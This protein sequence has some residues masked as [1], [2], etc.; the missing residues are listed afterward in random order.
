M[1]GLGQ[2]YPDLVISSPFPKRTNQNRAHRAAKRGHR[3]FASQIL[4]FFEVFRLEPVTTNQKISENWVLESLTQIHAVKLSDT[5]I[6]TQTTP[7][8]T[9]SLL[10]FTISYLPWI[11]C[12][13]CSLVFNIVLI[14]IRII[15]N[16]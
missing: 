2:P 11:Y 13:N 10:I 16:E 6:S 5:L 3:S 7:L 9:Y 4:L 1:L 14:Q 12:V 15:T 8:I